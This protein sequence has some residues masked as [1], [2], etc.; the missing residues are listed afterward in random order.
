MCY[1]LTTVVHVISCVCVCYTDDAPN[2]FP[3]SFSGPDVKTAQVESTFNVSGDVAR[4]NNADDD[5]FTQTGLF[6]NKVR[7]CVYLN[8]TLNMAELFVSLWH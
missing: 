7:S 5:N 2:Y 6:W 8:T 4:Y 1:L 3:N